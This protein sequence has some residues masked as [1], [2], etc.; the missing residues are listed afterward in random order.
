MQFRNMMGMNNHKNDSEPKKQG[1]SYEQSFE[2]LLGKQ[3]VTEEDKKRRDDLIA[4][5]MRM[6]KE[7]RERFD[8]EKEKLG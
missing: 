8:E 7:A 6:D 4:E 2:D 5:K 1:S 3:T